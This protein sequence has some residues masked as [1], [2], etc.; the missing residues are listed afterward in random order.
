M[1]GLARLE[2]YQLIKEAGNGKAFM[3]ILI[4]DAIQNRYL[5]Q[6]NE[7]VAEVDKARDFQQ[8]KA[9]ISHAKRLG[10]NGIDLFYVFPNPQYNF[11]TPLEAHEAPRSNGNNVAIN[12]E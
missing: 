4:R 5:D 10:L 3:K 7:W 2:C 11:G 1:P 12:G 9:A 6:R 8:G